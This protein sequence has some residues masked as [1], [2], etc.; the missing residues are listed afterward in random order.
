MDSPRLSHDGRRVALTIQDSQGRGDIWI[1][2]LARRVSARFTF[3][4]AD[5]FDPVWSPDDARIVFS[6]SRKGLGDL[7][8]KA[9]TGAGSDELLF[10]S[11]DRK[12]GSDWSRDGRLLIFMTQGTKTRADLW[13]LSLAD[14]KLTVFLQTEFSEAG[15]QLSPDGRWMAYFSNA[16]G[17]GEV[18]VQPFPGP[19][20][21]WQVSRDGA[22]WP[23]WRGDGK[24]LFFVGFDRK[25][26]AVDVKTDSGF[27]A[28]DA[29]ALFPTRIKTG[30]TS[31]EYDVS[32]D[33]ERFLVNNVISEENVA[34]ITLVQNWTAGLKR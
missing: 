10:A 12:L 23:A 30:A 5:D 14:R 7:Y 15:G 6:S 1:Y 19:G 33:G 21:K 11:D 29:R 16:S 4:P 26:M 25:L 3:D 13:A 20:G 18:Y 17:R 34:P 31:R 32:S 22:T 28:G 9:A 2:D 8:Q 27:E 24:E